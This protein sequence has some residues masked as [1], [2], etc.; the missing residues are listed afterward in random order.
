MLSNQKKNLTYKQTSNYRI[1][2]YL[3]QFVL[4][5]QVS[6]LPLVGTLSVNGSQVVE[7]ERNNW[8]MEEKKQPLP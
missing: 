4:F 3:F 6:F 2:F 5:F 8:L 1:Y 7:G